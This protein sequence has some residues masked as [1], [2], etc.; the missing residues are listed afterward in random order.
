MKK[1]IFL[2]MMV[3]AP[4]FGQIGYVPPMKTLACYNLASSKWIPVATAS[5]GTALGYA[6]DTVAAVGM[7]GGSYY[8]LTCD[9]SG[10]LIVT[11]S[12]G[13]IASGTAGYPAVYTGAT[14]I[15]PGPPILFPGQTSPTHPSSGLLA[16]GL[17]TQGFTRLNI[18]N[19]LGGQPTVLGRD[20]QFIVQNG[21]ASVINAGQVVHI[22][23][24]SST[25]IPVVVLAKADSTANSPA[26]GIVYSTIAPSGYGYVMKLGILTG[27]NTVALGG[28]AGDSY[29]LSCTAAGGVTTTRPVTPCYSQ[30]IGTSLY[31]SVSQGAMFVDIDASL[32]NH[33]SGTDQ[34]NF[35]IPN[36]GTTGPATAPSGACTTAGQWVFSKDGHATVCLSSTWTTKI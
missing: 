26:Q 16:Y 35:A 6:P 34:T 8:P 20:N 25:N 28:A 27:L 23:G 31:S 18:L 33:D 21:T 32:F 12:G 2:L 24:S 36:G 9:S 10:N 19:E 11:A 15:G 13:T 1:W 30:K 29:F 7:A 5:N 3:A 17:T 14:A 22:T 4:A